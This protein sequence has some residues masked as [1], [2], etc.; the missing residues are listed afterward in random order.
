V[1]DHVEHGLEDQRDQRYAVGPSQ[2]A[3]TQLY[4]AGQAEELCGEAVDVRCE[5]PVVQPGPH[6][7]VRAGRI[8]LRSVVDPQLR[9]DVFVAGM[10][11]GR[12]TRES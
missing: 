10:H 9:R 3:R 7:V 2:V 5:G 6:A 1:V 8:L 4:V 12:V 11:D